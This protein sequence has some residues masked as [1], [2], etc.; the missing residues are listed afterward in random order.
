MGAHLSFPRQ[1]HNCREGLCSIPALPKKK[2]KKKLEQHFL[3]FFADLL[4]V[5]KETC[6]QQGL[7][8]WSNKRHERLKP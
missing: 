6:T 2:K 1:E 8:G 4:E 3:D 7:I 5:R